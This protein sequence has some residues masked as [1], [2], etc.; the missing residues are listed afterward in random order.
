MLERIG[1]IFGR[2]KEKEFVPTSADIGRIV[3]LFIKESE[4]GIDPEFRRMLLYYNGPDE[5]YHGKFDIR[6][7]N[8]K[9]IDI[10]TEGE[11]P[12]VIATIEIGK[13]SAFFINKLAIPGW[14]IHKFEDKGKIKNTEYLSETIRGFI[15]TDAKE[16]EKIDVRLET[17]LEKMNKGREESATHVSS[18]KDFKR[19]VRK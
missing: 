5:D 13:N 17:L 3:R 7:A 16:G 1:R 18:V 4:S 11:N 19:G 6:F 8:T 9:G 15:L 12:R 10:V 14:E 2:K